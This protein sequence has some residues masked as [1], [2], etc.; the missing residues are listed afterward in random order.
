MQ[1][2]NLLVIGCGNIFTSFHYPILKTEPYQI[3]AIVEPNKRNFEN[4]VQK[5]GV[6]GITYYATLEE[7]NFENIDLALISSPSALHAATLEFLMA[8]S[9]HIFCEKPIFTQDPENVSLLIKHIQDYSKV[10]QVGY[11]RRFSNASNYIKNLIQTG[12]FGAV[13][14]VNMKGGWPAKNDLPVSITDKKLSGGGITMD[15]GSHF[16]DHCFFWFNDVD[17]V[18]YAD[19]SEGGIEINAAINLKSHSGIPIKIDLSWTNFMGN[20]IQV[21]FEKAIVFLGFNNPNSIEILDIN[22]QSQNINLSKDIKRKT[23]ETTTSPFLESPAKSEWIEFRKQMEGEKE[24]ISNLNQAL[25]VSAIIN[26]C[27][28]TRKKLTLNWGY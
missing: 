8:K 17:L 9:I 19:D 6:S 11:Y 15:Y 27:Y 25:K 10:I 22:F 20:F 7:V 2:K 14:Y 1:N 24:N 4:F 18:D 12:V 13:N 26:G 23:I 21:Q 28:K 5:E 16:I 3:T